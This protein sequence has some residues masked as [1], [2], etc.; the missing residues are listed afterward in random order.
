MPRLRIREERG[1]ERRRGRELGA[2][3]CGRLGRGTPTRP[4]AAAAVE[5]TTNS[6]AI[7]LIWAGYSLIGRPA[8]FAVFFFFELF[9]V[10]WSHGWMRIGWLRYST[11]E[12]SRFGRLLEDLI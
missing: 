2:S 3:R 11:G 6:L 9:V 10:C 1:R 5:S 12:G 4:S 8:S 7:G